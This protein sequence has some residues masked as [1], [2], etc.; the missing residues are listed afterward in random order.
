MTL[1]AADLDQ[2][3]TRLLAGLA[4]EMPAATQLRHRLHA[5]PRVSG[6][7]EDTART[8]VEALP[9]GTADVLAETGRWVSFGGDGPA[10][11]LRAELDA[12]PIVE[13]TGVEWSAT[14]E[15]MHACGHDVHLAALVAVCRVAARMTLPSPIVAILQP[16]EEVA[17]AGGADVAD[18]GRLDDLDAVIA[19]HVQ[20][21]LP[22]GILGVTPGPTNAG[23]DVIEVVVEGVGGHG[24][25]PHITRDPV[26]ALCQIVVSLQQLAS[27]RVDPTVGTVL[28]I[29][30]VH[31]GTTSNVVPG[32]AWAKGSF[33]FMRESDRHELHVAMEEI[34]T[35]TALAHGC[36]A[37][38][39]VTPSEPVLVND[40]G[41]A[42]ATAGWLRRTGAIVDDTF[43]SFGA[44]DFSHYC[45][46]TRGLMI[47]VGTADQDES[48]GPGLHHERFLPDDALIEPLA[49]A[50]VAG[51]LG[52]ITGRG[53]LLG[54]ALSTGG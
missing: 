25:Y 19:A 10:I 7:E 1:S 52:A 31:A 11:G 20:P 15:A 17:P 51:Y 6:D 34:V 42:D 39:Q 9:D 46:R 44:D 16:R 50:L 41:L 8:V 4:A 45:H 23:T 32:R 54:S 14:G 38:L 13:R 5:D 28:T 36:T 12:L 2:L 43:R 30:Q 35:H 3:H 33:R 27:R 18:S 40:A 53:T 24:G 49:Q 26:L 37:K 47:F 48:P 21:Q 29:G 22:S